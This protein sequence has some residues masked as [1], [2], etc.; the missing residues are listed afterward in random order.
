MKGNSDLSSRWLQ[1]EASGR[2]LE[3]KSP[4]WTAEIKNVFNSIMIDD[5]GPEAT[6]YYGTDKCWIIN[7]YVPKFPVEKLIILFAGGLVLGLCGRLVERGY[8]G[9][10]GIK[11]RVLLTVRA[12]IRFFRRC[13]S[14]ENHVDVLFL[15]SLAYRKVDELRPGRNYHQRFVQFELEKWSFGKQLRLARDGVHIIEA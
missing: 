8:L 13:I 4:F 1:L 7:P 11:Y 15:M 3:A 14:P 2:L 5:K 9:Y 12:D 6:R 10:I